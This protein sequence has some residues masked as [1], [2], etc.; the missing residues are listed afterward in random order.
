MEHQEL[1]SIAVSLGDLVQSG[2]QS[3]GL[4]NRIFEF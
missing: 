2:M 1:E 3:L 4:C